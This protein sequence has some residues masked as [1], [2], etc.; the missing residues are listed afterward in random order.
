MFLGIDAG[1]TQIKAALIDFDGM[2]VDM[3]SMPVK[4]MSPFEGASEMDMNDLWEVFCK[5][6]R[7]LEERNRQKWNSVGG[8]GITGQG[9][10]LWAVDKNGEPVRN[11]ILWNDTRTKRM[12][13][14]NRES[15]DE[16]CIKN[17][18]NTTYAGSVHILLRWLKE[19]EGH[20]AGR[21]SSVF[22]CKDWLN[23]KLTG[24]ILTDYSDASLAVLNVFKKAYSGEI[25][26]AMG[27]GEYE[28]FFPR[29]VETTCIIG[30]VN[31]RGGAESGIREGTPVIA[32]SLDVA[33]VALGAGVKNNGDACI[34]VGTTLCNEIVHGREQVNFE[35]GMIVCHI[36]EGKYMTVMPTLSGSSTIDWVKGIL[37]PELSFKELENLLEKVPLGSRGIIYHPYIYGER[38]PF[39]NPFACGGFYGLTCVHDRL[40]MLRAAYEGLVYSMYDCCRALPQ[41]YNKIHIS[42]GGSASDLLCQMFSDCLGESIIRPAVKQL[43]IYG[44]FYAFMKALGYAQ[45]FGSTE[46]KAKE[47]FIPDMGKHERYLHVYNLFKEIRPGMENFW[48]KRV[49]SFPGSV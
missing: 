45:D 22:H 7:Q 34:I 1:T 25:L 36:P 15:I 27:I 6:T 24:E 9:D 10:G 13:I 17:C 41:I 44:V 46:I 43:G 42:G 23:F 16:I 8:V 12:K 35:N 14:D 39:K 37:A 28:C 33:S 19:F 2:L 31:K 48:E 11:A 3:A 40:D 20:S 5:L 49:S 18:A 29:P 32:G 30:K 4:V 38:A 47:Y 26:E 21:I